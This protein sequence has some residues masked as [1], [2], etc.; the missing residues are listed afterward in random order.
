MKKRKIGI[1]IWILCLAALLL[2]L[3]ALDINPLEKVIVDTPYM[4]IGSAADQG[5][6]VADQS[7][8]RLYKADETGKITFLL[9]GDRNG[10]GFYEAKQLFTAPDGNIYVLDIHRAGSRKM[11]RERILCYSPEGKLLRTVTDIVYEE[12]ELIYKN[13]INRIGM[14]NGEIVWFRLTEQG[15][16]VVSEAGVKQTVAYG[17]AARYLVDFAV[18][19]VTQKISFLTKAGEIFEVQENGSFQL[20]YRPDQAEGYEIPWYIG[21]DSQG[22]LLYADI[23]QRTIVRLEPDGALTVLLA[24]SSTEMTEADPEEKKAW[25]IYYNFDMAGEQLLTTDTYGI[26]T[27]EEGQE[28]AYIMEY[29]LSGTLIA[30]SLLIWCCLAVAVLGAAVLLA[31]GLRRIITGPSQN[32]RIVAAMLAGTLLLTALFTMIILRDWNQRMTAEIM[33]RT[34]SVSK[35]AADLVPGD[36]MKEIRTIEDYYSEEYNE[37]RDTIRDIFVTEDSSMN[38]LY[39]VVYRIQDGM[40]TLAYS[41]EDYVGSIYPYDW[42][43]E[44]S[45]EQIIMTEQVQ[46]S[47]MGLSTSEGS[48][49]FTISPILDSQGNSVGI[50]EVGTDLYNFQQDNKRMVADVLISAVALAVTVILIIFELLVFWEGSKKRKALLKG[51]GRREE[52]PVSMTRLLVFLIFFVTNMPKGFLPIYIMKQAEAEPLFGLSPAMLVS[53]ALSAEV[54]CGAVTSFGGT[55]VLR[56][57]GRRKTAVL[58]SILFV[59]GLSM[60]AVVP[61]VLSFIAGNGIMG[62]GWGLLLLLVQVMIAERNGEEKTEGFT[63]YTAASLSG[64]NCGVVFGAFLINWL[65]YRSV[66]AVIG[67]I[68]AVSLLFACCY[69]YDKEEK[70]ERPE[71]KKEK[72]TGISTV[73]FLFSPNVLLYFI[74]VVIPVVAG[75]YFLAYLYPLLGEELGISETNIGYSYLINGV[76]IIC[77]GGVLTKLIIRKVREKGALVSAALLYAGAFI[78][79]A[80]YPGVITLLLTLVLLGVSDSYGLPAQSTYYTDLKE[81]KQYGYDKAMGVYSLFEN[82]A[83]VFGSFV[84]GI[85]YVNGV[86][87]GLLAAGVV[88]GI[89]ALL[90]LL[91]GAGRKKAEAAE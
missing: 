65:S 85:I 41:I 78:L 8:Q 24:N 49:I 84:F 22:R 2:D 34:A 44:G 11:E 48:F 38:D 19:P 91:F 13:S 60:R 52:L 89:A 10:T 15:F 31:A 26:V 4:V 42:P 43:Y 83:Q 29:S 57:L 1:V 59:G 82:L 35:L 37:I 50:M 76:C 56:K 5:I 73:R 9:H 62:V 23:G 51:G 77:L 17:D 6:V 69:I 20:L 68:S 36:S 27:A 70:T 87:N 81:V 90:F 46:K 32:A 45:D 54:L 39:C 14:Q 61:T 21:Y 74:G 25:P 40:I 58:G 7:G 67:I 64:M 18:N 80:L 66:L 30:E 55:V 53:I 75:G 88:I 79:Y 71:E 47:Y 28:A 33:G 12:T 3:K 72:K 86:R 16:E 63:G